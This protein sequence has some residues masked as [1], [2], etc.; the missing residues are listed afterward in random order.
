M[1]TYFYT[2]WRCGKASRHSPNYRHYS[3][4]WTAAQHA[5]YCSRSILSHFTVSANGLTKTLVVYD[6]HKITETQ[7]LRRPRS[8]TTD[9]T[10][11]VD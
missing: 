5:V 4:C 10:D 6:A 3:E 1:I 7:T 8:K 9:D 11:D 2:V